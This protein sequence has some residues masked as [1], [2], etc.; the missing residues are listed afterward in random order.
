MDDDSR[1]DVGSFRKSGEG[2]STI[3]FMSVEHIQHANFFIQQAKDIES[4]YKTESPPSTGKMSKA[5]YR[6]YCTS[7]VINTVAFLEATINEMYSMMVKIGSQE[8]P[9][10]EDDL[11]WLLIDENITDDLFERVPTLKKYNNMLQ[12]AKKNEMNSGEDPYQSV[13]YVTEIRNNFIHYV[14]ESVKVGG[15]RMT[16]D[17]Y[18][19]EGNIRQKFELNPFVGDGNPFFPDQCQSRG[20]AEWCIDK[21]L[22]FTDEFFER[23]DI[24][25]PYEYVVESME[26]RSS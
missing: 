26:I 7:A 2:M 18:G 24:D 19:F 1:G 3:Q 16:N 5:A 25:P 9:E 4:E 14:P 23:M 22:T 21:S 20:C 17:E 13:H 8:Y 11:F 6:S 12:F 10:I 15:R